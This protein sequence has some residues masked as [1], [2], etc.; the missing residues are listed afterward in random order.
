MGFDG[1]GDVEG[2]G[3]RK[4]RGEEGELHFSGLELGMWGLANDVFVV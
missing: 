4:E 2:G 3:G 1:G